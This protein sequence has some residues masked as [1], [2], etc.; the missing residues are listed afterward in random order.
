MS[1]RAPRVVTRLAAI[2][3]VAVVL[4][5]C[6]R[7]PSDVT[8]RNIDVDLPDGWYVFE[9]TDDLL[10]IS[11]VDLAAYAEE[12][13]VPDEDVVA[14]F[15]SHEPDALPDQWRRLIEER[16]ATLETD[17]RLELDRE[18]PATRLIFT[19]TSVGVSTREMVVLIPSR[20]VVVLAQPVPRPGQRGAPEL[21]LEH[22]GTFLDVLHTARLGR[23]MLDE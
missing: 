17:D 2:L 20:Q 1:S 16:G 13:E 8:W 12:G 15:F 21:F 19:D 14:M 18:V 23:P 9:Q 5:A 7:Q 11:N 3:L 4:A 6:G 10:S 22:V